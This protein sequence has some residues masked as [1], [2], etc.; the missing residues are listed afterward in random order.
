MGEAFLWKRL[1]VKT[2][3]I[4]GCSAGG[5]P[6]WECLAHTTISPPSSDFSQTVQECGLQPPLPSEGRGSIAA[7]PSPSEGE[8]QGEGETSLPRRTLHHRNLLVRQAVQ[9]VDEAV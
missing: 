4:A 6:R 8:G 3:A 2:L 1:R 9:V 7:I 5:K